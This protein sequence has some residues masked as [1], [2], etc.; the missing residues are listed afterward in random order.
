MLYL[1]TAMVIIHFGN[2]LWNLCGHPDSYSCILW[3]TIVTVESTLTL[4]GARSPVVIFTRQE[5]WLDVSTGFMNVVSV[6][7]IS[8]R[9]MAS[10]CFLALESSLW[11]VA[12][13]SWRSSFMAAGSPNNWLHIC[14]LRAY[15][16]MAEGCK[17]IP[18]RPLLHEHI[19]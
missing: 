8:A 1:E 4:L 10:V 7:L 5:G 2:Y 16:A 14:R 13:L 11:F 3:V 15:L 17:V 19:A 9:S 6:S 18:I 12:I